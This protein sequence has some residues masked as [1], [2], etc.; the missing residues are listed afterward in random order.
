MKEFQGEQKNRFKEIEMINRVECMWHPTSSKKTYV[1]V[2]QTERVQSQPVWFPTSH[3]GSLCSLCLC[4]S[5]DEAAAGY[6]CFSGCGQL[7]QHLSG[8]PGVPRLETQVWWDTKDS[9]LTNFFFWGLLSNTVGLCWF[10]R[11][12]RLLDL[13]LESNVCLFIHNHTPKCIK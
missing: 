2:R 6:C 1:K 7:C 12:Y 3:K 13:N 8:G 4:G 10:S 11:R 5:Q 9:Y